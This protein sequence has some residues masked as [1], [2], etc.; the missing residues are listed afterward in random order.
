M[1]IADFKK[2]FGKSSDGLLKCSP[3]RHTSAYTHYMANAVSVEKRKLKDRG[4]DEFNVGHNTRSFE[5]ERLID[6]ELRNAARQL[7]DHLDEYKQAY[8]KC[9]TDAEVKKKDA[10]YL[11]CTLASLKLRISDLESSLSEG[12]SGN[13]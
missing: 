12:G 13:E 2:L 9:I 8:H 4:I 6:A 7:S 10:E 1:I 3:Y 11:R 5:I